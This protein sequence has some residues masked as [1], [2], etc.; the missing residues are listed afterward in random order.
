[1]INLVAIW[2]IGRLVVQFAS[3]F[4]TI[5]DILKFIVIFLKPYV[6]QYIASEQEYGTKFTCSA[7]NASQSD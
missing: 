6:K 3:N 4:I 1:M 5:V 7:A 2:A